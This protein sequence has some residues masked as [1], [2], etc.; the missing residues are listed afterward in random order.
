MAAA[1]VARQKRWQWPQAADVAAGRALSSLGFFFL[2]SRV[3]VE[4]P[5]TRHSVSRSQFSL[6]DHRV[7]CRYVFM[8]FVVLPPHN[9]SSE[10]CVL[11][12][13]GSTIIFWML[14][15]FRIRFLD[16][17]ELCERFLIIFVLNKLQLLE[18]NLKLMQ[19]VCVCVYD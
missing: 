16:F 9:S 13:Y 19:S 2:E 3:V 7:G 15:L 14:L 11:L 17:V 4:P 5:D 6:L 1:A 12:S 8:T 18:V 10:W